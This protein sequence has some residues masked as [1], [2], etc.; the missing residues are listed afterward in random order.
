MNWKHRAFITA[1][2]IM[3]MVA[4]ASIPCFAADDGPTA[5]ILFSAL[6]VEITGAGE[7]TARYGKIARELI[8][9]EGEAPFSSD[10]IHAAVER[11]K[12]SG[13]FKSIEVPDPEP[14]AAIPTLVFRLVPFQRVKDVVIHGGFPLLEKEILNAMSLLTG[15]SFA[16][17]KLDTQASLITQ[18][19]QK[20][21]YPEAQVTLSSSEDP[22]DGHIVVEV[23]I[24]KGAFN[25]I[26]NVEIVGNTAFSDGRLKLRTD[27][28]KSSLFYGEIPRFMEKRHTED[29]KR[30]LRFYRSKGYADAKVTS[31][32]IKNDASHDVTLR[33][34]VDEGPRYR[35]KFEGNT[36]F[37]DF[38]LRREMSLESRGNRDDLELKRSIRAIRKR[39]RDAG[40]LKTRVRMAEA[41]SHPASPE[42]TIRFLLEEGP[43][44]VVDTIT[45][46][47][48]SVI[49]DKRLEKQMLTQ[50]R[51]TFH[52]GAFV[53]EVLTED[54]SAMEVLYLKQGYLNIAITQDVSFTEEEGEELTLAHVHINV[55]EGNQTRVSDVHF[56]GLKTLTEKKARRAI[57]LKKGEPFREYM[58]KSDENT[59]SEN[60]SEK[61][62]PHVSV[63]GTSKT[64]TQKADGPW[65]T[66]TYAIDEG[67]FVTAGELIYIGNFRT[68]EKVFKKE[69]ELIPGEPFSLIR[70]LETRRNIRNINA[71]DSADFRVIGLQEKASKV[72]MIVEAKEKKPYYLEAGV[73]YDTR[74]KKYA[75]TRMGDRN[76]MGRNY[77]GWIAA[78]WSEIGHREEAGI[79]TPRFLGTH[80]SSTLNLFAEDIQEL[81]QS[82]GTRTYGISLGLHRPFTDTLKASL[83]S[84]YEQRDLYTVDN[85]PIALADQ[86]QYEPRS[87]IVTTPSLTYNSTDSFIRPRKGMM[88]TGSIEISRSI[89]NTLDDF[90]KHR[91]ELRAYQTP[92]KR[93][94]FAFRGQYHHV[95]PYGGND[96]IAED[97]RLYLGGISD[98]RG[99]EE[100][101]LLVDA[102]GDPVGGRTSILGSVEARFDLGLNVELTAFFDSGAILQPS[103]PTLSEAFRSSA[104]AGLRYITP[105]G[106]VGFLYGWKLGR[107]PGESIGNLH[108][109]IG[110]TF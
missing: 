63:T 66:V 109:S 87:I 83:T 64:E 94:T 78:E 2:G 65:T 104:G 18:V 19:F 22:D 99:F 57:A 85:D 29:V 26:R 4:A 50:L 52:G 28:W 101:S 96:T 24:D 88:G 75:N 79:A 53:P 3:V 105:I 11:L 47:G 74:R 31:T 48:N 103:D 95:S 32:A 39:Y 54:I 51:G 98:V 56:E 30:L 86:E 7:E 15:D 73:G 93:L 38:T 21:G 1:V 89:E 9:M 45:I 46:N 44:T 97:Q 10:G 91:Y 70:M 13:I 76:L 92:V 81:N 72:N 5:P 55:N 14:G 27:S 23:T 16:P 110:Y 60:I 69:S 108:F 61:G 43:R 35:I 25:R 20:E 82:F 102:N 42:R 36:E 71:L 67:P 17:E 80:I 33:F 77:H 8:A 49:S 62:H 58:I 84:K 41:K 106:P 100:N 40:Y 107:E 34:N 90:F 68:R 12:R 59:L 6:A 37:W